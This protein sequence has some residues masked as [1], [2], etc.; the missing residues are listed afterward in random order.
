MRCQAQEGLH[1]LGR[2]KRERAPLPPRALSLSRP[3]L[4]HT[5]ALFF[6]DDPPLPP[7]PLFIFFQV[8]AT[9]DWDALAAAN[10]WL[11]TTS[12]VV[13]PDMLFGQRGKHDLVGLRLDLPGAKAFTAARL[14]R[15]I[16][17]KAG[18]SGPITTFLVEPFIPH[19]LEFY[20]GIDTTRAGLRVDFS[21]AGGVEVEANWDQCRSVSLASGAFNPRGPPGVSAGGDAAAALAPLFEGLPPAQASAVGAFAA[22]AVAAFCDLD[23]TLLEINPLTLVDADVAAAPGAGGTTT[24]VDAAAPGGLVALPLDMRLEVDDTASYRAGGGKK[25]PAGLDLPLPFGRSLSEAEAAVAAA[26]AVT[27]AS[28]KLTILNPRGRVW[29]MVAGGG[30]SVIY[31]DTVADLGAAGELGNYAEYSGGPT[32][33]ETF[34]YARHLIAAATANPDGRGRALIIGGGIANFTDVAATFKGIIR[35]LK[36]AAP[37]LRAAR[38]KILVR[39]GGPNYQAGLAAMRALALDGGPDCLDVEVNGPDKSMTCVCAR[40]IEWVRSFD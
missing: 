19:D 17:L 31:A 24:N 30:A 28:L 14:G 22:G 35:A 26:D 34:A 15:E 25:W 18:V 36:E 13:K 38:V 40:A 7:R 2:E 3:P 12:L 1:A 9:T 20:F 32:E 37:A 6:S 29:T 5:I 23:A 33:A 16:T 4:D 10:P 11:T 21:P 27:G 39:R 8:T